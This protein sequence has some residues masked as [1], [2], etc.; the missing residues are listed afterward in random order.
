MIRAISPQ[1][2]LRL[3]VSCYTRG[4]QRPARIR[5]QAAPRSN[6]HTYQSRNSC[7]FRTLQPKQVQPPALDHTM[8]TKATNP[9]LK[10]GLYAKRITTGEQQA[11]DNAPVSSLAGEIDYLRAVIA[12]LALI[13]EKNGLAA[14]S[15]RLLSSE[16]R[17]TLDTLS[18]TMQRLLSF[19]RAHVL[20]S[21]GATDFESEIELGKSWARRKYGVYDYFASPQSQDSASSEPFPE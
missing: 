8:K 18:E 14:G 7:A 20:L 13:L 6:Q 12:R 1:D 19:V 15:T 2:D 3:P 21:A 4:L 10:H 16:T 5:P 11:L 9:S 17:K